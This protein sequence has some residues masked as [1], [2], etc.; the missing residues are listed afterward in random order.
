[1]HSR[2]SSPHQIQV[3]YRADEKE[4]FEAQTY[5]KI[6]FP[7]LFAS[8]IF[9]KYNMC[10]SYVPPPSKS[11]FTSAGLALLFAILSQ[12][13]FTQQSELLSETLSWVLLPVIFN[14]IEHLGVAGQSKHT[15]A[16]GAPQSE[17]S[18]SLWILA[19]CLASSSFYRAEY[20]TVWLYV[21]ILP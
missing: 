2:V 19:F 9:S 21:S 15:Q 13:Y 7:T 8:R 5:T 6:F 12:H 20:G 18:R 1:M 16:D 17:S 4:A 11:V 10:S 3:Q 14:F